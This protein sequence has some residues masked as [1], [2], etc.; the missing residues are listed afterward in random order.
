MSR[1]GRRLG[2]AEL[3]PLLFVSTGA[4]EGRAPA[5]ACVRGF[6]ELRPPIFTWLMS[7]RSRLQKR[8]QAK[9]FAVRERAPTSQP[10][11]LV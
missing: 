7:R 5:S 2:V 3:H 10:G 11:P 6:A 9:T 8:L 4:M 1:M